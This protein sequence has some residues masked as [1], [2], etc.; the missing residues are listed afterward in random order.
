MQRHYLTYALAVLALLLMG[1]ALIHSFAK[2]LDLPEVRESWSEK[3][4][5]KVLDPAAEAEGRKSE[6]SCDRLPDAYDLV[7]VH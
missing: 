7:W 5:V 4:C 1:C 2:V 3:K 6:W